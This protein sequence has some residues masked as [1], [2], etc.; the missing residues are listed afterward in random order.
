MKII[1]LGYARHG[2]D[3]AAEILATELN[4]SLTSSSHFACE[5]LI[6]PQLKVIYGYES[7]DECFNDRGNHRVEWY[8]IIAHYNCKDATRL[9]RDVFATADIYVG[10]RNAVE[11]H[12]C[13]RAN[14]V[15]LVVWI[16]ASRRLTLEGRD[17]CT[18]DETMAH[19]VINNNGTLAELTN[20]IKSLAKQIRD[21]K[22]K[23][24]IL[25]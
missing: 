7:A 8:N 3:T 13:L 4:S 6:Y 11:L 18:V 2:K 22:I 1:V 15:D 5:H 12:A 10:M 19:H 20:R 9:A 14:L 16:D 21:E 24:M 25:I 23:K 17:S